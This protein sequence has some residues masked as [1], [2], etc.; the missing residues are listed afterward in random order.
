MRKIPNKNIKKNRKDDEFLSKAFSASNET[1][2]CVGVSFCFCFVFAVVS[3][4]GGFVLVL[5]FYFY[6]IFIFF[7]VFLSMW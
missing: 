4:H 6:F 1:M 3:V 7:F 2:M 5:V